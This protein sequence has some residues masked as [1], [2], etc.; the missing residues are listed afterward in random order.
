MLSIYLVFCQ[1]QPGVAYVAYKKKRVYLKAFTNH[2]KKDTSEKKV[3]NECR[4]R[5]KIL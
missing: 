2:N 1:F 5:E 4:E 3:E